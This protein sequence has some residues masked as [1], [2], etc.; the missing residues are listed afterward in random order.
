MSTDPQAEAARD[1]SHTVYVGPSR[2]GKETREQVHYLIVESGA[3][4]GMRVL[5]SPSG[6]RIGREAPC[7]IVLRDPGISRLHCRVEQR[8]DSIVV[9]DLGSTNGSYIDGRQAVGTTMFPVGSTLEIGQHVIRH[10][11]GTR[12]EFEESLRLEQ[13]L[14][15]AR[16]YIEALLP[17][18]WT[19]GPVRT[20]WLMLPSAKL[21]GDVLGYHMLDPDRC[22]LYLVDVSGHGARAAMHGVSIVNVL[23]HRA[24][25][26]VDFARPAEVLGGLNAMFAMEAHADM[27]FTIWYGIYD[28]S[29]RT[30]RYGSGGHHP[31]Y[32]VD[33]RGGLQRLFT[34]NV[35]L[36]TVPEFE[37]VDAE[38]TVA[39]GS[40]LYLFSD[41]V[42]ELQRPDGS[43]SSL[44]DFI[45]HLTA[46][47]I[48]G[49]A[50]TRRLH[51]IS[52]EM[53]GR[54]TF[55]DDYS[56]LVA[57]ID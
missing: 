7:E 18:P 29:D 43:E 52:M 23:R 45:V 24:L 49:L 17:Q 51:G 53:Q 40:R 27:Y 12:Q 26:N 10:A 8:F 33:E 57:E 47:R 4:A 42:F 5:I 3:H 15:E 30:L 2:L 44:Q 34:R 54:N 35:P 28:A 31:A 11:F 25:P 37:F 22:A 36:G 1:S 16:R 14:Q 9:T 20:E 32:L 13:E 55:D 6:L 38:T 46:G 39:P 21:G 41:G 50:E 56:I 19:E 48:A